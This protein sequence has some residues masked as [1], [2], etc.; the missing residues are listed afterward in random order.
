[1]RHMCFDF[2]FDMVNCFIPPFFNLKMA[3]VTFLSTGS[4]TNCGWHGLTLR[5]GY[6]H[7]RRVNIATNDICEI[8]CDNEEEATV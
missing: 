1:M 3:Y 5:N 8:F 4:F 2:K 7:T 6:T